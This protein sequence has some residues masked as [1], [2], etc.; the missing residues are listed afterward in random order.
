MAFCSLAIKFLQ[1]KYLV[2]LKGEKRDFQLRTQHY[3]F[4]GRKREADCAF[5]K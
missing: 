4:S 3:V 2:R 5:I 1:L